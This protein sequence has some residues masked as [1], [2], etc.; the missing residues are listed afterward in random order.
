MPNEDPTGFRIAGEQPPIPVGTAVNLSRSNGRGSL[1]ALAL[2]GQPDYQGRL[3]HAHQR[4]QII[5]A[6]SSTR[7]IPS[8]SIV[9]ATGS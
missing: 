1:H 8:T 3:A 2:Q 9:S 7:A 5:N 6:S 4:R